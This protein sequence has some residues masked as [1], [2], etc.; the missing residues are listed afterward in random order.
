[1]PPKNSIKEYQEGGYYHVY[2]RGVEKRDIFLDSQDYHRF[3]GY[4]KLYLD[5]PDPQGLALRDENGLSI[6]PSHRNNNFS[7]EVS[8]LAYCLMPNHYH[9]LIK[10]TTERGMAK[11]MQSISTKYVMY[12]NRRY[13]RVGGLFQGRYKTVRI[14][15]ENQFIGI[16]KYIHRNPLPDNPSGSYLEGLVDYK[17]SSYGNYLGLFSQNW[18]KTDDI[19]C[20]YPLKNGPN[21]YK[22]FVEETGDIARVY[23]EMIDLDW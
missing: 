3:I 7:E 19:L 15:S 9:L 8:L 22:A 13:K 1:M 10:Q 14:E 12:F 20:Y 23:R 2:N 18:V 17:Y 5:Q 4:L 6:C 21:S 11:F 16:S